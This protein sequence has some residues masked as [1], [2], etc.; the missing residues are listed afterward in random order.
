MSLSQSNELHRANRNEPT[1]HQRRLIAASWQRYR[2]AGRWKLILWGCDLALFA[3][4]VIVW[5]TT[6][7]EAGLATAAAIFLVVKRLV[8][9]PEQTRA[10]SEA[11]RLQE[12]CEVDMFRLAWNKGLAGAPISAA[13]AYAIAQRFRGD[14][15]RL[16]SW[17]VPVDGLTRERSVLLRQWENAGWAALDYRR[18]YRLVGGVLLFSVALTIIAGAVKNASL[19][20]YLIGLVLPS[21]PW[22]LDLADHAAMNRRAFLRRREIEANAQ[23]LLDRP[24]GQDADPASLRALQDALF[25]SRSEVGHVPDWFYRIFRERNQRLYVDLVAHIHQRRAGDS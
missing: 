4:G 13:D 20:H 10:H 23:E 6:G 25:R 15:S 17:Y 1:E 2:E 24:A 18:F 11:V 22:L 19:T 8:A 12:Q 21:M 5:S 16:D 7:S 3:A 14:R 9:D